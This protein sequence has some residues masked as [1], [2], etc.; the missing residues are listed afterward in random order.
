MKKL[1][2]LSPLTS[3]DISDIQT[4]LQELKNDMED[5]LSRIG[6][7][8]SQFA[9]ENEPTVENHD[10]NESLRK[11]VRMTLTILMEQSWDILY[12]PVVKSTSGNARAQLRVKYVHDFVF[13]MQYADAF[14]F[15]NVGTLQ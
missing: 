9:T 4:K 11:W 1:F 8:T 2:S 3:T 12:G 10:N 13:N 6:D 7:S 14:C 15:Q 5:F